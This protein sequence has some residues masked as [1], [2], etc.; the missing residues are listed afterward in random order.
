V[1]SASRESVT[2]KKFQLSVFVTA[3][4]D[5]GTIVALYPEL[6]AT[7]AFCEIWHELQ[8]GRRVAE[9]DPR[10]TSQMHLR[11]FDGQLLCR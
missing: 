9:L 2:H 4:R 11:A 6:R 3:Q 8:R 10:E 7:K 5:A 1:G